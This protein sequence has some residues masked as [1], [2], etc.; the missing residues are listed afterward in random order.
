MACKFPLIFFALFKQ[1]IPP[2]LSADI[3]PVYIVD[4]NRTF[5]IVNSY[6]T[7]TGHRTLLDISFRFRLAFKQRPMRD[8]YNYFVS[9]FSYGQHRITLFDFIPSTLTFISYFLLVYLCH[10]SIFMLLDLHGVVAFCF[11]TTPCLLH[12]FSLCFTEST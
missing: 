9:S 8:Y 5:N 6:W 12:L 3:V 1:H 7:F 2:P 4:F 11:C 10:P